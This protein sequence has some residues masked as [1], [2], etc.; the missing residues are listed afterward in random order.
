[1]IGIIWLLASICIV[2]VFL[3]FQSLIE[4]PGMSFVKGRFCLLSKQTCCD[5]PL[6]L[7]K[8][9]PICNFLFILRVGVG[10]DEAGKFVWVCPPNEGCCLGESS[11]VPVG[12]HHPNRRCYHLLWFAEFPSRQSYWGSWVGLKWGMALVTG[13]YKFHH[14]A[15]DLVGLP[16]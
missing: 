16:P 13:G 2:W 10:G 9:I 6:P 1:M 15:S 11:I 14:T 8:N 7:G 12:A 4:G 5:T 3:E